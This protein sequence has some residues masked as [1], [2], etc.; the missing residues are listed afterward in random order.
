MV[1]A[2]YEQAD[3]IFAFATC[4]RVSRITEP[5]VISQLSKVLT[6]SKRTDMMRTFIVGTYVRTSYCNRLA[7]VAPSLDDRKY[8]RTNANQRHVPWGAFAISAIC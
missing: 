3:R 2:D 8:S 7:G 4:W 5:S 1:L 6:R